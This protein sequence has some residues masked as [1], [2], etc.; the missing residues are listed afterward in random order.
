VGTTS[1]FMVVREKI[2][3]AQSSHTAIKWFTNRHNFFTN[4][5]FIFT[6]LRQNFLPAIKRQRRGELLV[7]FKENAG[8]KYK[9]IMEIS[10]F[11]NLSLKSLS[12]FYR[13]AKRGFK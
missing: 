12:D 11:G 7:L 8:L 9:E 1:I 2:M 4:R 13:R 10:V 3:A 5:R 6:P